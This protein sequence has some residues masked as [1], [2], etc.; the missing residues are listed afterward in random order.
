[1]MQIIENVGIRNSVSAKAYSRR[2]NTT[3]KGV[4]PLYLKNAI[5]TSH[6]GTQ[7]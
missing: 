4:M 3:K 6:S 2:K 7:K 1:M 5:L